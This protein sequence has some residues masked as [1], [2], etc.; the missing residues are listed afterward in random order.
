MQA[1]K[2]LEAKLESIENIFVICR[3]SVAGTTLAEFDKELERALS[4]LQKI[5]NVLLEN[6]IYFDGLARKVSLEIYRA[7][8][9]SFIEE[10]GIFERRGIWDKLEI[11]K[12]GRVHLEG[13]SY[14]V[15]EQTS[16][17]LTID[18]NSG[19]DLTVTKK[20]INL[21]ACDEIFRIIRVCG[22]G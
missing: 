22:H 11:I 18:L 19:K 5:N 21:S 8:I 20:Q 1:S 15:F 10:E 13:G 2:L 7:N 4:H 12:E 16:A 17:F 14:L 6:D 9:Y 3:S